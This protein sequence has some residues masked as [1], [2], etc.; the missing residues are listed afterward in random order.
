MLIPDD[1]IMLKGLNDRRNY[2]RNAGGD[3][4]GEQRGNG[5]QGRQAGK[6]RPPAPSRSK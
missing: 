3:I 6:R 5:Y 1:S 2:R 4:A